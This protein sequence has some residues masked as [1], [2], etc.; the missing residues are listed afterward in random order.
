MLWRKLFYTESEY[1]ELRVKKFFGLKTHN[2]CFIGLDPAGPLF[3]ADN[4]DGRIDPT[5]ADAVDII[6]SSKGILSYENP[7]GMWDF[8]PNGGHNQPGCLLG[9][10][11]IHLFTL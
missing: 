8:Y 2:F 3:N 10:F 4:I 11:Y 6:H 7:T 9:K 1:H 5:D